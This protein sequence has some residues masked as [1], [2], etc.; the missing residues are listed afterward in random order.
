MSKEDQELMERYIYQVVR[1]LPKAQQ[2]EVGMELQELISDMM[3]QS[4]SME[5]VLAELGNPAEFAKS[6]RDDAHCLIGPEYYDTY[7]WFMKVVICCAL[8]S[9]VVVTLINEIWGGVIDSNASYLKII[10]DKTVS[11]FSNGITN[12]L[13]SC[14]EAFGV[15]TFVFAIMERQKV[16]LE[17]KSVEKVTIGGK[18]SV[19]WNPRQL[20]AVPN[21]KAM[22]NRGDSIVG[23]VF[24]VFFCALLIAAPNI[25][26]MVIGLAENSNGVSVVPVFN[27]GQWNKI[28]PLFILGLLAALVDEILKLIMGVYCRT[29]MISCIISGFVQIIVA[30]II[31]KV[32]PIWNPDLINVLESPSM[33]G[34]PGINVLREWILDGNSAF[35]S[36]VILAFI[37]IGTFAEIG[38]TIYKTLRYGNITEKNDIKF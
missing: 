17:R 4:G 10:I 20:A 24:I 18:E 32:L 7:L 28:L 22:I 8:I 34:N 14:M 3:E 6:Y 37:I 16:K 26:S 33:G 36:N 29:V 23:I 2:K 31:V 13:V 1:R 38:V 21:K 5:E 12:C 19:L 15:V 9:T 27:Q 35:M 25:F 11:F 30:S